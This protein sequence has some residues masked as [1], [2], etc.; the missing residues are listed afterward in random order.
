VREWFD[1]YFQG[2]DWLVGIM[3]PTRRMA[4]YVTFFPLQ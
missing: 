2:R 1:D 3:S 4:I